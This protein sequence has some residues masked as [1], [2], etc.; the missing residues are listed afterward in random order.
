[1]KKIGVENKKN[2]VKKGFESKLHDTE[3]QKL[4]DK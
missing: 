3:I 4:R 2:T 1:M